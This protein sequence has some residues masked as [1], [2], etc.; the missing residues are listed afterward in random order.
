LHKRELVE[1]EQDLAAEL[2]FLDR[3]LSL[4]FVDP[5]WG[6]CCIVRARTTWPSPKRVRPAAMARPMIYSNLSGREARATANDI[7]KFLSARLR[8]GERSSAVRD[9]SEHRL[10][11]GGR[12]T[13][14]HSADRRKSHGTWRGASLWT[15]VGID[16]GSR[17]RTFYGSASLRKRLGTRAGARP[18]QERSGLRS[19]P[20]N[21]SRV[22]ESSPHQRSDPAPAGNQRMCLQLRC[23]EAAAS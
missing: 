15:L 6:E 12:D 18:S 23:A 7:R 17:L 5:P 22:A 19:R 1:T 16:E 20:A 11:A 2:Q 3:P 10:G 4:H 8:S 14:H 9:L 21:V 13:G